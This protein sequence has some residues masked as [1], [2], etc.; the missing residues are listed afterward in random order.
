[1]EED[2]DR[3]EWEWLLVE[4]EEGLWT[5]VLS[6]GR[7]LEEEAVALEDEELLWG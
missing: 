4:D 6:C 3:E 7:V 1:L 5:M 2:A